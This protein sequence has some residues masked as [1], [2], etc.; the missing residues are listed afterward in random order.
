[1]DYLDAVLGEHQ[2]VPAILLAGSSDARTDGF[3]RVF[4]E[5]NGALRLVLEDGKDV[6]LQ[7]IVNADRLAARLDDP[8]T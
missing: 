6:N 2:L 7:V 3:L 1:M 8:S 4:D 5:G